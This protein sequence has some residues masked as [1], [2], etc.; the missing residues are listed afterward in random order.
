M[1]ELESLRCEIDRV[2][3]AL[4]PLFLERMSLCESVADYKRSNN[5]PVLD[6]VREKQVLDSK[7]DMLPSSEMSEEVYE[8]FNSLMTISRI[9]QE[10]KLSDV[11]EGICSEIIK[12]SAKRKNRPTVACFGYEGSYSEEAAENFFG[13]DFEKTYVRAFRD[14]FEAVE[15]GSADYT[16]LPIEN[17]STGMIAEVMDLLAEK[18]F[19]ITGEAHISVRHCLLA[20]KGTEI[21]D[22]RRIYSHE[23]A[24]MQCQE[25]TGSMNADCISCDSTALAARAVSEMNDNDVAAIASERTAKIYGLEVLKKGINTVDCNTTRFIVISAKPEISENADKISTVFTLEHKSGELCR[26]LSAFARG[27]LNLLKLES[28]PV[29][30]KPFEYKFFADYSGNL[31]VDKVRELTD[32]VAAG[33]KKFVLLGNYISADKEHK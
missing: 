8:F 6:S 1:S 11:R 5:M 30:E 19:Y 18:E 24:L 28:R 9:H 16:V 29:P 32:D 2:D 3:R 15:N 21:S 33:T 27:G 13:V 26:V 25:F 12:K 10:K 22:I 31:N 14:G 7:M 4:L 17:S 20:H 23:Q